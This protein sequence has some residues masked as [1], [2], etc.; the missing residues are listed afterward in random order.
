[1][2]TRFKKKTPFRFKRD[3]VLVLYSLLLTWRDHGGWS[4]TEGKVNRGDGNRLARR[5]HLDVLEPRGTA[6]T[7][8][9]C[10]PRVS[11]STHVTTGAHLEFG[12][13]IVFLLADG[14][15]EVFGP[16]WNG[17]FHLILLPSSRRFL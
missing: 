14:A 3:G 5:E 9:S 11:D 2:L 17:N 7:A 13:H 15:G 4:A 6:A 16:N 12:D 8:I 1:M 10:D